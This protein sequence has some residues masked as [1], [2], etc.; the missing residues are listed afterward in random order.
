MR[1]VDQSIRNWNNEVTP[2]LK[3]LPRD[4]N[5]RRMDF[6]VLVDSLYS[7]TDR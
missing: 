5:G 6:L 1:V 3:A 2:C 4:E 7:L